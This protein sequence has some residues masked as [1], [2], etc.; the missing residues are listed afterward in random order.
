MRS[1]RLILFLNSILS[2]II[3]AGFLLSLSACTAEYE[4]ANEIVKLFTDVKT[5]N[6]KG[7]ILEIKEKIIA[8]VKQLIV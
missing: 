5:G 2:S 8:I 3:L 7:D 1:K 4:K 6:A